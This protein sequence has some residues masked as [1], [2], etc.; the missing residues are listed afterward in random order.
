MVDPLPNPLVP[1]PQP[2]RPAA[3]PG[4]PP[5]LERAP[6]GPREAGAEFQALL[7][8]IETRARR[9]AAET[10]TV[11]APGQLAGAVETARESLEDVLNLEQRLLEAYRQ[12]RQQA[13][14]AGGGADGA[15]TPG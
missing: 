2:A 9:L 7:E 14:P 8:R 1:G 12:Q 13:P 3:A 4:A 5:G 6:A 11:E 15:G 10:D